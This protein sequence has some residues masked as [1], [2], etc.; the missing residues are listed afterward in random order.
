MAQQEKTRTSRLCRPLPAPGPGC[1]A[2]SAAP[3]Y[4]ARSEKT[5]RYLPVRQE[6][7]KRPAVAATC[8]ADPQT[9]TGLS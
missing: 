5:I 1:W 4:P 8:L 2:H 3:G 7:D 9:S 6:V